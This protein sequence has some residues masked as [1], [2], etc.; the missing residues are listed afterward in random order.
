MRLHTGWDPTTGR[1]ILS[2]NVPSR[3]RFAAM[4][5]NHYRVE[6]DLP[7]ADAAVGAGPVERRFLSPDELAVRTTAVQRRRSA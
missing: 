2:E 6:V 3:A 7:D 4:G 1:A 5:G